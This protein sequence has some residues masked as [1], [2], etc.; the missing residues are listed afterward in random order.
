[1]SVPCTE[2]GWTVI[3]SRGQFNNPKDYFS[4]KKWNDYVAGFGT[5][6]EHNLQK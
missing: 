3:Q 5:I 1:M 6:G 4:L 2:D